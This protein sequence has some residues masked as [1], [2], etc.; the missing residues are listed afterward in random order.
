M[1]LA[2]VNPFSP[3]GFPIDEENRLVLDTVKSISGT[4]GSKRVKKPMDSLE[5]ISFVKNPLLLGGISGVNQNL[6][7]GSRGFI[8]SLDTGTTPCLLKGCLKIK[9]QT[10]YR[11]ARLL[12]HKV[13]STLKL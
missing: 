10:I 1:N 3:V 6:N 2:V 4:I 12:Y 5:Q 8:S 7:T 11:S 13:P 9:S